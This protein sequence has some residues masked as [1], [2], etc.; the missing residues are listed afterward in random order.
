MPSLAA[1]P[2]PVV[3]PVWL[4]VL[5]VRFTEGPSVLH[6][7]L[8]GFGRVGLSQRIDAI[9]PAQ[10]RVLALPADGTDFQ[11]AEQNKRRYV[12]AWSARASLRSS[13]RFSAGIGS[14]LPS[15]GTIAASPISAARVAQA[16]S[17]A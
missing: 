6:R 11:T 17:P 10:R 12:A 3:E 2:P 4:D 8:P 16:P 9:E 1:L 7:P 13:V 14:E 15:I 5:S